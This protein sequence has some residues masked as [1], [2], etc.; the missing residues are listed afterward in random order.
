M[1]NLGLWIILVAILGF[2]ILGFLIVLIM[3]YRKNQ[4]LDKGE[5][6]RSITAFLVLLFGLLVV[7]SFFPL[8]IGLP[9]ELQG[10]F[11]GTVTTIIGFYFGSRGA[12]PTPTTGQNQV[13][14]TNASPASTQ[15]P[16]TI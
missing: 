1:M 5:M 2:S 13:T 14:P 4:A 9:G 6:R 11:A 16:G 15:P 3:G 10:L 7:S 8:G 12:T